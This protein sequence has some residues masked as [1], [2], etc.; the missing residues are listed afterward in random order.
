[1]YGT[2]DSWNHERMRQQPMRP[3]QTRRIHNAHFQ[4]CIRLCYLIPFFTQQPTDPLQPVL[5]CLL[6]PHHSIHPSTHTCSLSLPTHLLELLLRPQLVRMPALLL[7]TYTQT[8]TSQSNILP[9]PT[10]AGSSRGNAAI[11]KKKRTVGSSG[12]ETGVA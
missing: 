11:K 1:M 9:L 6:L 10:Q 3:Y 2:L 7:A 5:C 12:R 8:H 4:S